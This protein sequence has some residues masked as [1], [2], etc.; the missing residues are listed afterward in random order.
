MISDMDDPEE[1]EALH[2][3]GSAHFGEV[4]GRR[5]EEDRRRSD[6]IAGLSLLSPPVVRSQP[7]DSRK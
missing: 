1:G 2:N 3:Q 5:L 4:K 7:E 6:N